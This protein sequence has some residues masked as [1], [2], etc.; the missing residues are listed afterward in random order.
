MLENKWDIFSFATVS[1]TE[2]ESDIDSICDRVE[3]GEGP[4]L[5]IGDD[6]QQ[7]IMMGWEEYWS[8]FGLL[9]PPGER[10]K[11]E[12]ACRQQRELFEN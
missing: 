5:I 10:E 3:H 1:Q 6:E 2:I 9:Y 4:F 11:I 12:E 7:M 8:L